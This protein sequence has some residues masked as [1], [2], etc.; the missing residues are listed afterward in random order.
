MEVLHQ[1]IIVKIITLK[2]LKK[3]ENNVNTSRVKSEIIFG[4]KIY[5]LWVSALS[6]RF[7][8]SVYNFIQ[9]NLF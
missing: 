1:S 5:L 6:L 7:V 3:I 2:I 8:F 9:M 4:V